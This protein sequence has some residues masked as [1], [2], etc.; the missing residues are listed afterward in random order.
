M[1]AL[2]NVG[3]T[4]DAID[5]SHGLGFARVNF[6]GVTSVD[7]M[8]RVKKIGTGT[9]SWQ[10]WNDTDGTQIG[11]IDDTVAAGAAPKYMQATFQVAL[12]GVKVIRIRCKS[13]I[14]TDDPVFYG[15]SL[16]LQR[17]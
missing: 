16:I 11:V 1:I 4:Y 3:T 10:L 5:A 2:T 6:T 12:S 9:V 7:L 14:A 17:S 15:S 8:V 13:T